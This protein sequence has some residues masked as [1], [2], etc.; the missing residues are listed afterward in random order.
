[1]KIYITRHGNTE[2]NKIGKMQ[3]WKN[4]PLSDEGIKNAKNL[5]ERLKEI[6]FDIA[7]CSTLD[8]TFET[9]NYIKGDRN[10]PIERKE[11][12]KEM[13][14]GIWEGMFHEHIEEIY[15]TQRNYFWHQPH[16]YKPVNGE[17]FESIFERTKTFLEEI[18]N[19]NYENILVVT[20]AVTLKTIMSII[21]NTPLENLWS[22]PYI[23]DT[24]LTLVEYTDNQFNVIMEADV[25]HI[26]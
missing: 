2:W 22:P 5:G 26:K 21:K 23:K 6:D 8:R 10:F 19:S 25:S 3:G 18:T 9:L 20:H 7:Y 16:L 17:T 15:P 14:F 24:S 11:E 4:S 1:M 13:G 12:I